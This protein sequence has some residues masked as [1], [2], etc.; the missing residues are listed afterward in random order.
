VSVAVSAWATEL[1]LENG[2]LHF[3]AISGNEL[4]A[5]GIPYGHVGEYPSAPEDAIALAAE[6][7]GRRVA[8]VPELITPLPTDG[9]PQLARWRVTLKAPVTIQAATGRRS[10]GELMVGAANVGS[11]MIT[12]SVAAVS[13][14]ADAALG[15]VPLPRVGDRLANASAPARQ[16]IRIARRVDT[17]AQVEVISAWEDK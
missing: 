10:V 8:A 11:K 12:T 4:V 1:S 2:R 15:W 6:R 9:P 7:S 17:P 14:P 5:V 3:P 13:Q 16:V